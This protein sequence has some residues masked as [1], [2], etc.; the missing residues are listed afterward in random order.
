VVVAVAA[1]AGWQT[2]IVADR[3]GGRKRPQAEKQN[4][5]DGKAAPHLRFMLHDGRGIGQVMGSGQVSSGYS[6]FDALTRG[7]AGV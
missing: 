5:E 3:E 7:N 6:V 4:Q 2:Q 1:A